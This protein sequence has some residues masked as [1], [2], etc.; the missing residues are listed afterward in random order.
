MDGKEA[1]SWKNTEWSDW[2]THS[3]TISADQNRPGVSSIEFIF[4]DYLKP[5]GKDTRRLALMFDS[6]TFEEK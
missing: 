3:V 6:I 1:G 5:A 4:S 2:E